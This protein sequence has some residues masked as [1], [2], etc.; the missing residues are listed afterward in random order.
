MINAQF[1]RIR[2]C[3]SGALI[4]ILTGCASVPQPMTDADL[5][6]RLEATAETVDRLLAESKGDEAIRLLR[7]TAAESPARKEPWGRLAKLYFDAGDYGN[8]I[9]A[10]DE[11][12]RRDPQER[13]ALSLRAV[14]GLRVATESLVGLRGDAE[15]SGSARADASSLA[16]VLRETLGEE[17]LVPPVVAPSPRGRRATA[18]PAGREST[19][20]PVSTAATSRRG[21]QRPDGQAA[22]VGGDPFSVLK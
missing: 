17:V 4:L 8:A 21:T 14:G 6:R 3:M 12:L 16:K 5:L 11:V 15:L 2:S 9:V 13:L 7:Q 19:R 18:K 20:G 1:G 22:A 10:A